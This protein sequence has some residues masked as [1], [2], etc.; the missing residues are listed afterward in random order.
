M[1]VFR[2]LDSCP[3]RVRVVSRIFCRYIVEGQAAVQLLLRFS[4]PCG[5]CRRNVRSLAR[6]P[7]CDG[8]DAGHPTLIRETRFARNDV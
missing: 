7:W 2:R 4:V 6:V 8:E 1:S 5:A 3:S